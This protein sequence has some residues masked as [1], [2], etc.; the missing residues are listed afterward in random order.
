M[1]A[2]NDADKSRSSAGEPGKDS[3]PS[4]KILLADDMP[5]N[6]ALAA[7]LLTRR[8]HKV[9]SVENGKQAVEAFQKENFDVVLMDMQMPE[10]DGLEAARIIRRYEEERSQKEAPRAGRTPIIAMTANDD[11]NDRRQCR[12]AGMDGF[13]TKPIEIKTVDQTI[14]QII[15]QARKSS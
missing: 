14:R 7:K 6:L 11:E 1:D 15:E 13:I 4:F 2:M 10:I 3:L 8:G 12:E 5:M 9:V